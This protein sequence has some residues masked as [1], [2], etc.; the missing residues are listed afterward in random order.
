[1]LWLHDF[2]KTGHFCLQSHGFLSTV[3]HPSHRRMESLIF[4]LSSTVKVTETMNELS[5]VL[6]FL[7][8][9]CVRDVGRQSLL[10]RHTKSLRIFYQ[11][12]NFTLREGGS[13]VESSHDSANATFCTLAKMPVGGSCGVGTLMPCFTV[14]LPLETETWRVGFASE[15]CAQWNFLLLV[16]VK[17]DRRYSH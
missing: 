7:V 8:T 10:S 13:A 14:N 1:M 5:V 6:P 16:A 9:P 3:H 15:Y 11:N 17:R 2:I 4:V 12:G